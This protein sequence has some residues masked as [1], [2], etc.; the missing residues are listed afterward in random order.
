MIDLAKHS[1]FRTDK[2]FLNTSSN[3]LKSSKMMV[4]FGKAYL[5]LWLLTNNQQ[6]LLCRKKGSNYIS[7]HI[8]NDWFGKAQQLKNG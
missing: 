4:L 1:N 3:M 5:P 7:M 6:V 2:H 8:V